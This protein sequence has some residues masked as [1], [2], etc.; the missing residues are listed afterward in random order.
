MTTITENKESEE[1]ILRI[2]GS[3]TI[4]FINEISKSLESANYN[5]FKCCLFDL[6]DVNHTDICFLQFLL[7]LNNQLEENNISMK[8]LPL[9]STNEILKLSKIIGLNLDKRLSFKETDDGICC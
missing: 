6:K 9:D 4:E 2:A 1:L 8:L 7:C 5:G 3:A